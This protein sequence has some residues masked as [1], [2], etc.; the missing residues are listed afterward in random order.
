M[1]NSKLIFTSCTNLC[2]VLDISI[3]LCPGGTNLSTSQLDRNIS[4]AKEL[5]ELNYVLDCLEGNINCEKV[6]EEKRLNE[7]LKAVEY[8]LNKLDINV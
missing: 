7:E 8:I 4:L 2:L 6:V 1:R 3:N 5:K